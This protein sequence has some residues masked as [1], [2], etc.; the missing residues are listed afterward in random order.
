M[1]IDYDPD[2]ID[3]Q[4]VFDE[5]AHP[6]QTGGGFRGY[7]FQ[8]GGS[9]LGGFLSRLLGYVLPIAKSLG[10]TVG[11][12]ALLASSR[13][14]DDF[15]SGTRLSDALRTRGNESYQRLVARAADKLQSG[16][17]RNPRIVKRRVLTKKT[18]KKPKKAV[19]PRRRTALKRKRPDTPMD[20]FGPIIP[21]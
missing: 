12:E 5:Q 15:A 14:A 13:V 11:T 3:W 8:R 21:P 16:E 7:Q 19:T 10:R 4:S 20:I 9:A 18:T 1:H 17:G 2:R 6:A